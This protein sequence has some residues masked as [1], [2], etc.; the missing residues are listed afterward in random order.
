MP[1]DPNA[2]SSQLQPQAN[3]LQQLGQVLALKNAVQQQKAGNI[4]LQQH[5]QQLKDQQAM[6]AA[7]QEWDGKDFNALPGLML[8]K[9]ASAQAVMSTKSG[10]LEQQQK[11]A[12]LGKDQ[13]ANEAIKNDRFAQ[14][15]ANVKSLSPDQQPQAFEA[16]KADAVKS[17][18]MDPAHAQQLVYQGPEQLDLLE[19][20]LIGHKASLEAADKLASTANTQAELP[21]KQ[22][23]S[24]QKQ[25][26]AAAN[27]LAMAQTPQAYQALWGQLPASVAQS[28][29]TP[30]QWTPKSR[31]QILQAGMTPE[32]VVTTQQGA[33]RIAG[34]A[35]G[36][37]ET[38]RH[39]E[40]VEGTTFLPGG[41]TNPPLAGK[42]TVDQVPPQIKPM[43]QSILDYKSKMP[44]ISARG[45]VPSA[46]NYW[47]K[48]IDPSYD[49]AEFPARNKF[50]TNITSGPM[51]KE[52]NSINTALGHVGVLGD[53]VAAL[54]NGNVQVLNKIANGVGAQFGATPQTTFNAIVHRVG[55][56]LVSAYTQGG[57][58][59][60]ERSIAE[61]DFDPKMGT[62]QLMNNVGITA[63]L[64]RSKIGAT[65]NQYKQTMKRDDFQQ[66]FITSEAQSTLDK[67][68]PKSAGGISVTDPNGGVHTFKTQADAANFKRDAG[69]K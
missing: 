59:Q 2:F 1:I 62:D 13:L 52:L 32:Q 30:D 60:G 34:E 10:I 35:A 9:G 15:V 40:A 22:A 66:R 48:Q 51:A 29:P 63:K 38:K 57:G 12:T 14:S 21:G 33:Q 7:M 26:M 55:P 4:E 20:S 17:G 8:K 49:E 5:Q 45:G 6:T 39:N 44:P 42:P 3:P 47:V 41:G 53:A 11:L 16:A 68:S 19:K 43:V 56:E 54:K 65:E 36:R 46:L 64:L 69:I 67:F 25:R 50:L 24:A 27:K 37:A 58:G 18:Y 28:F 31:A 23:D 61:A